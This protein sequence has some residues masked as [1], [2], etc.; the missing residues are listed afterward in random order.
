MLILASLDT[1][2]DAIRA[3]LRP[4]QLA[5]LVAAGAELLT[6][7]LRFHR[8]DS[9]SLLPGIDMGFGVAHLVFAA[10]FATKLG[11]LARNGCKCF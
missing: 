8:E 11:W 1:T 3:A 10:L 9:P 4:C 2:G 6:A 7:S 5:M